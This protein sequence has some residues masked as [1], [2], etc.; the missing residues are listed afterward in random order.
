MDEMI[1]YIFGSL[2]RSESELRHLRKTLKN[3]MNINRRFSAF[4]LAATGYVIL[5]EISSREQNKK[6]EKLSA[7][8]KELKRKKGE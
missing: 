3:Q 1:N 5:L 7:E 4:A 8:L 6:I 2:K